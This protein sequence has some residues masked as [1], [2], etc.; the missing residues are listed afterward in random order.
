MHLLYLA[1]KAFPFVFFR[2]V[3]RKSLSLYSSLLLVKKR[4]SLRNMERA[5][6]YGLLFYITLVLKLDN[7]SSPHSNRISPIS[8]LKVEPECQCGPQWSCYH[9]KILETLT[10]RRTSL[11]PVFLSVKRGVPPSTLPP[12]GTKRASM[13]PFAG[14]GTCTEVWKRKRERHILHLYQH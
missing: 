4:F 6:Y 13:M 12:S 8:Q 10:T 3:W 9:W 7:L 11:P 5:E 1:L 2:S 14:D